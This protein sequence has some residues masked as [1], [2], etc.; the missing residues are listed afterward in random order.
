MKKNKFAFVALIFL[1]ILLVQPQNFQAVVSTFTQNDLKS[2]L[3]ITGSPG[4]KNSDISSTYHSKNSELK[5]R[6]YDG[7]SQVIEV[8]SKAQFTSEELSV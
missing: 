8:H 4:E 7:K 3:N 1:A 5:S 2:Q 6:T